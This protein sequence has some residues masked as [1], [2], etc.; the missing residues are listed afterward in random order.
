MLLDSMF[1]NSKLTPGQLLEVLWKLACR[2]PVSLI[3]VLVLGRQTSEMYARIAFFRDVA[4][5]YEYKYPVQ[6]GG[7]S[8]DIRGDRM[9]LIGT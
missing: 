4:G 5:W 7:D 6:L 2:T 9:F 8:K 1:Y 3:S